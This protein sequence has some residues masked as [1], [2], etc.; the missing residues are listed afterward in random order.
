MAARGPTLRI[1]SINDVYTLENLPRLRN[2]VLH[3]TRTDPADVTL[4]ILAGD[5]VAP[6]LLSS[7][8]SGRGMVAC[9]NAVGVTHVILGNHEDD[10]PTGELLARVRELHAKW[11][12]TNVHGFADLPRWDVA[13]VASS[14]AARNVRVGLLGV[15]MDDDVVYRR[16]PFGGAVLEPP[17]AAV[18]REATR[19]LE[20]F[21]CATVI[22][23]T[24][25]SLDADREL[26]RDGWP[27][28]VGGHEHDV[29]LEQR[30]ATWIVKAGSDAV[31]AAVVDLRW[32]A[33][34][35]PAGRPDAP[36]VAVR[37]DDVAR[38]PEDAA[39]RALIEAHMRPV[40]ALEHATLVT[41]APGET[42][43]SVGTRARQTS[44]GTLVCSRLRD[45][46]GAQ[47]CLFNGGGIRG[48][49]EYR[50]RVTY[51]DLKTEVPFD[52]EV[53]VATLP[54]RVVA[55]AVAASRAHAPTE[56]A[57]FLQVDDRVQIGA[58]GAVEAIAGAPVDP[59]R[60]YRV[61]LIRNLFTGL[62]HVGPLVR[63][64]AEHPDEV[65]PANSGRDVKQVLVDAFSMALWDQLGGFDAV[66]SDHDGVV[67]EREL[68]EAIAKNN[69]EPPS[70]IVA[71]LLLRAIDRNHDGVLTREEIVPRQA[72]QPVKPRNTDE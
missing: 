12:G 9:M 55:E 23:I 7:L 17:N 63:F 11:I 41:L 56:Y 33:A 13:E 24:H 32:P 1:L 61:A 10:I 34:A 5:F 49:R 22:P 48:A 20:D 3:H 47:A 70:P 38:Y 18:R 4:V 53:V 35:P 43:S 62:D 16:K 25:Q 65:P 37:L 27:V 69:H 21:G 26:A 36:E 64:A 19:L 58:G 2:L 30:G 59:D 15:V 28:I 45:E 52:N 42:L 54:G 31:H 50:D 60:E 46:L 8:D 71:D 72:G 44:M 66:D 40:H 14:Q 39:L 68:E 29:H 6:S 51:G 57:G 67:G